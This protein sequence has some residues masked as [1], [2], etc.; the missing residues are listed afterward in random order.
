[1]TASPD[2]QSK[3]PFAPGAGTIPKH[4][5]GR[6]DEFKLLNRA[7]Q[8]IAPSEIQ[9]NGLLEETSM[10]PLVL[11]GPRGVGKTLLLTWMEERAR[12]MGIH[13]A[14]LAHVKDLTAGEDLSAGDA[15]GRLLK[16]IAGKDHFLLKWL[17]R[18]KVL[19]F[20]FHDAGVA[21]DLRKAADDYAEVLEARLRKGPMVLLMDEAHHY[22]ENIMGFMLQIGQ[23][24]ISTRHPL[25]ILLAGTPDLNSY[26]MKIGATFMTRSKDIYINLLTT[27]ESKE[28]LSESFTN[29]GIEVEPQALE[30]MWG[31]TDNYP[32]FVQLVGSEVWEALPDEGKRC[33]DVALVEQAQGAIRKERGIFYGKI[34][35]EMN[36]RQ[37]APYALQ[38]AEVI[39]RQKDA[40]AKRKTVVSVLQ[41]KNANLS[42]EDAQDIVDRLQWLGF[43][44]HAGESQMEAGIPSFFTY[45]QEMEQVAED[46]MKN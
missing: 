44:W 32:F 29:R 20:F 5:V 36:K 38:V 41:Q 17:K 19:K 6:R 21:V 35:D 4:V 26:L 7:L 10:T 45:L 3:N 13:V 2:K 18:I 25:L 31:L 39:T 27:E 8:G 1:M 23:R 12:E 42:E 15:M 28:A 30:M 9:K 34:Y 24:L 14:R 46:E 11:T 37:L 43:I 33:V 40:T 16:D 22:K